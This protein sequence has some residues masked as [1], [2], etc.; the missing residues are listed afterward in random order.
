[1]IGL[2][3]NIIIRLLVEDDEIQAERARDWLDENCSPESPAYISDLVVV[4]AAWTLKSSFGLNRREIAK[5]LGAL[6][7]NTLFVFETEE[8]F[9]EILALYETS[10]VDLADIMIA[11]RARL[12]GC[13]KTMTFDRKAA[14][15]GI[16]EEMAS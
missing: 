9:L 12:A 11:Y 4:E 10:N 2:D 7:R 16:M 3:T 6:F 13:E 14:T 5:G 1:M 15:S 8:M